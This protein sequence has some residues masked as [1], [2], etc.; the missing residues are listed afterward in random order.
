MKRTLKTEAARVSRQ[1]IWRRIAKLFR[2]D[3]DRLLVANVIAFNERR[4]Y[5]PPDFTPALRLVVSQL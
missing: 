4:I 2:H 1:S 5:L 3:H